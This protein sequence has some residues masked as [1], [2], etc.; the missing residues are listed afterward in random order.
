MSCPAVIEITEQV[1]E[2]TLDET[3]VIV[4][5]T[6]AAD[7]ELTV[8]ATYVEAALETTGVICLE[9]G[10]QGPAGPPGPPGPPGSGAVTAE[11]DDALVPGSPVYAKSNGHFGLA[12]ATAFPQTRFAGFSRT[13]TAP[14]FAAEVVTGGPLELTPAEWDTVTSQVGG[15]TPGSVYFLSTTVAGTITTIPPSNLF[16][17]KVGKAITPTTLDVDPRNPIKL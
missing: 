15:L 8:L 10:F 3:G 12:L 14:T 7:V 5:V 17:V 6:E 13:T 9:V 4:D 1:I 2:I 11:T 16:S